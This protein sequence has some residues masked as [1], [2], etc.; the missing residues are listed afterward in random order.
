MN[1]LPFKN[2]NMLKKQHFSDYYEF[3]RFLGAGSYGVVVEAKDAK[4]KDLVAVK[5]V[6]KRSSNDLHCL[7][8]EAEIVQELSGCENIIEF[9]QLYDTKQVA[10]M[11]IEFVEGGTLHD[12]QKKSMRQRKYM[13]DE[14]VSKIIKG[15]L[16]G[17]RAIHKA[18]Y[19]HRDLKPSNIV[20]TKACEPKI[21]DF[22]L[23]VKNVAR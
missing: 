17:L 8:S 5:I 20:L 10:F 12:L 2:D 11:S 23:A 19:V 22:G 18:D 1:R 6:D 3:V 13:K 16:L 14:Q 4:T 21:I 15:I 7:I 9:K